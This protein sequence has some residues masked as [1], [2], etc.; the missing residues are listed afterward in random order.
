MLF[1]VPHACS[2]LQRQHSD[3]DS[4]LLLRRGTVLYDF[5]PEEEDEVSVSKGE[6]VEVEYEVGGWVQVRRRTLL[7]ECWRCCWAVAQHCCLCTACPAA[8]QR[9]QFLYAG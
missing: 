7:L 8:C 6:T 1:A 2:A 9:E 3:G 5:N 4:D